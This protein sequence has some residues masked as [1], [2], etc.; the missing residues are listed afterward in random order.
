MCVSIT[1]SA[2]TYESENF[3]EEIFLPWSTKSRTIENEVYQDTRKRVLAS[4]CE[5]G[6]AVGLKDQ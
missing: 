3:D 2:G 6:Q 4:I 5:N 1:D